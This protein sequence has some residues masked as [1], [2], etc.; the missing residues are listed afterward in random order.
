MFYVDGHQDLAYGALSLGRDFRR[1]VDETRRREEG[2][3]VIDV[4]GTCTL[5]FP[6]M[7]SAGIGLV[8]AT[9]FTL[10]SVQ[11]KKGELAYYTPEGAHEQALAQLDLYDRWIASDEYL[12]A[13]HSAGDLARL[14]ALREDPERKDQDV[15]ILLLMENAEPISEPAEIDMW[16]N[17]GVRI[18]GPAWARN[19]YTGSTLDGEGLTRKGYDLLKAMQDRGM[20]LDLTHS[21][22]RAC[23]QSL[24]AYRG[25]VV[26]THANARALCNTSRMIPDHI[27]SRLFARDGLFGVMPANWALGKGESSG[28]RRK[29]VGMDDF[30]NAVSFLRER[31]GDHLV[32]LGSDWDGGFGREQLPVCFDSIA[33]IG[34]IAEGLRLRGFSAEFADGFMGENW[35]KF[36]KTN[37]A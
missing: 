26:I 3:P 4:A 24:E 10:P 30:V 15:G 2:T 22:D 5:G 34:I 21:S 12:H 28:K 35:L 11:Q 31:G 19:R 37:L 8:F 9:I 33:D 7:R 1:P 27:I 16:W 13:I 23:T 25:P 32:A 6:E 36:L 20:V 18:I 14:Q 17:R 29:E